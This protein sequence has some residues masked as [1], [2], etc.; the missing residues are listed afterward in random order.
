[1]KLYLVIEET[2]SVEA[3]D[4]KIIRAYLS[5]LKADAF[6]LKLNVEHD[7]AL[8]RAKTMYEILNQRKDITVGEV[9]ELNS[10]NLFIHQYYNATTLEVELFD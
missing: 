7:I 2:G 10:C 1:M 6:S 4:I 5:K 9:N 8:K 3:S